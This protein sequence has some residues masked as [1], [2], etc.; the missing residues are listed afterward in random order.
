[1]SNRLADYANCKFGQVLAS[2]AG[3]SSFMWQSHHASFVM[4]QSSNS[5]FCSGA[6]DS[7]P[8]AVLRM[9]EWLC[10]DILA[11]LTAVQKANNQFSSSNPAQHAV[12]KWHAL[13]PHLKP[14][15]GDAVHC[16]C[17]LPQPA[18]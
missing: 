16:L 14:V 11:A 17:T 2:P 15:E 7:S 13:Q 12:R 18:A 6:Y 10:R 9:M 1:M 4:M 5:S 3:E 8:S